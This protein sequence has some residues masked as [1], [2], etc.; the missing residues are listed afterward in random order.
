MLSGEL[1]TIEGRIP[2]LEAELATGDVPSLAR[3]LRALE[4]RK[5]DLATTLADKRA[6]A[7]HP[8]AESWV[9]CRSIVT[10]LEKASDPEEVRLRLRSV[11]RRIVSKS[12]CWSF[13][14]A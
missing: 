5:R 4:D 9:E 2:D 11:L 8:A 6:K 12:S 14:S 13:R 3:A 7:A 1:A 10:V